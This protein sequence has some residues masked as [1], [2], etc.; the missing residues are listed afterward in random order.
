MLGGRRGERERLTR[1]LELKVGPPRH[2]DG[3]F[4]MDTGE[5]LDINVDALFGS[6]PGLLIM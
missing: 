4:R 1:S 2:V 6:T 5:E 3:F